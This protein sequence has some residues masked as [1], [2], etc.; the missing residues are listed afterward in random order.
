MVEPDE[1]PPDE[2]VPDGAAVLPLIPPELGVHPLL[3][4]VLHAYVF[5]AGS[6]EQV[7]NGVV[8]TRAMGLIEEYCGRLDGAELRRAKEDFA[9][10]L[11]YAKSEKWPRQDIRVLQEVSNALING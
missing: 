6:E 5:L 1:L 9:V 10:L 3:L 11:T 8:A 2:E 7:L 4:A